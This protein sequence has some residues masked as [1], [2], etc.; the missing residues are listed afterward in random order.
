MSISQTNQF[1][2]IP[3]WRMM[4]LKAPM[5]A[6]LSQPETASHFQHSSRLTLY[7]PSR[8]AIRTFRVVTLP[9][10]LSRISPPR[11]RR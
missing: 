8:Q 7:S 5:A 6:R 10:G 2:A 11:W 4:P 3:I 9:T 1:G